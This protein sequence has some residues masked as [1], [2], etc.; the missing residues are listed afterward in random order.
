LRPHYN[1][2]SH[3]ICLEKL[4]Q[5]LF[6]DNA[7]AARRVTQ[8]HAFAVAH[9]DSSMKH[10]KILARGYEKYQIA[11]LQMRC[12]PPHCGFRYTSQV[13][14]PCGESGDDI[15]NAF[16]TDYRDRGHRNWSD[17]PFAYVVANPQRHV[18][19]SLFPLNAALFIPNFSQPLA[20][21]IDVRSARESQN[22]FDVRDAVEAIEGSREDFRRVGRSNQRIC[23]VGMSKEV[24]G[25]NVNSTT[26]GTVILRLR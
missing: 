16:P 15:Q 7:P 20:E 9:D 24:A 22:C 6:H 21:V 26:G 18:V 1:D 23:F 12:E 5:F 10:I 13:S 11:A 17:Y 3:P 4:A 25:E 14:P 2:A 19:I 8:E